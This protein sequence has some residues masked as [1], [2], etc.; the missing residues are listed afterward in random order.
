VYGS[1]ADSWNVLT[2]KMSLKDA[3]L[4]SIDGVSEGFS[5]TFDNI[6]QKNAKAIGEIGKNTEQVLNKI[7]TT[8]MPELEMMKFTA[9][10]KTKIFKICTI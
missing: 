2:G 10:L 8:K 1:V 7:G 5:K 9:D 4:D 6:I 3:M